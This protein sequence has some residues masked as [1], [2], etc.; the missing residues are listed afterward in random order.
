MSGSRVSVRPELLDLAAIRTDGLINDF[1]SSAQTIRGVPMAGLEPSTRARTK[2]AI[3]LA[4]TLTGKGAD[5]ASG[6]GREYRRRVALARRV[7]AG[8]MGERPV[9][10]DGLGRFSE[11]FMNPDGYSKAGLLLGAFNIPHD[12]LKAAETWRLEQRKAWTR[13]PK[14]HAP[15]V[16]PTPGLGK[17]DPLPKAAKALNRGLTLLGAAATYQSGVESGRSKTD[18]AVKAAVT[19]TAGVGAGAV[20]ATIGGFTGPFA[21]AASPAL[22]FLFGSGASYTTGAIYDAV[23]PVKKPKLLKPTKWPR[24]AHCPR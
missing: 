11:S 24:I 19:T 9:H 8:G 15:G 16:R 10:L 12:A 3:D 13:K 20:G 18:A 7:D 5:H 6:Q 2:A 21:P 17:K 4:A 1:T 22:A 14:T 23:H